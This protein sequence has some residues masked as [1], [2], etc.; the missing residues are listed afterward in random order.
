MASLRRRGPWAKDSKT[1]TITPN[2][3]GRLGSNS[4]VSIYGL[5]MADMAWPPAVVGLA[6]SGNW[7]VV[8]SPAA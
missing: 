7:F 3:L 2:H 4:V 5:N 8:C 6:F 1:W